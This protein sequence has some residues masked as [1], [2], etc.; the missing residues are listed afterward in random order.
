[1]HYSHYKVINN[2]PVAV[3]IVEEEYNLKGLISIKKSTRV[4]GKMRVEN[5]EVL[6]PYVEQA[7]E[8]SFPYVYRLLLDND[9]QMVLNS[10]PKD[11]KEQL[12][13]AFADEEDR[14]EL[15]YDGPFIY[16]VKQK[17]LSFTNKPVVYQINSQGIMVRTSNK[18]VMLKAMPNSEAGSLDHLARFENVR[19]R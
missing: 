15:Y 14:I 2:K 19:I 10:Q 17:T 5:Y 12:Y 1:M 4:N 6:P 9:K 8:S 13:Y 11:G 18:T 16:D 3:R 7:E